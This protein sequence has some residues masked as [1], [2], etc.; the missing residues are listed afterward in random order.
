MSSYYLSNLLLVLIYPLHRLAGLSS[1]SLAEPDQ[2]LGHSRETT[3]LVSCLL[4]AVFKWKK[5]CTNQHM[6]VSVMFY[7]K[8]AFICLY[9]ITA[10]RFF[11]VYTFLCASSLPLSSALRCLSLPSCPRQALLPQNRD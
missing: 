6:V 3:V 9:L 2:W 7:L 8:V 1:S 4:F 11:L 10:T 5:Y